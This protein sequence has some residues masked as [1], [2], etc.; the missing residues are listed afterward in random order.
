MYRRCE[1]G[2]GGT[3]IYFDVSSWPEST[4]SC[5][6]LPQVR[7]VVICSICL[8]WPMVDAREEPLRTTKEEDSC[9]SGVGLPVP[10]KVCER[11]DEM[12][13]SPLEDS[14]SIASMLLFRRWD[15]LPKP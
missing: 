4:T 9:R 1:A 12:I 15:V 5:E 7:S 8:P 14:M 6:Q 13:D 3:G 11:A 10:D 2:E